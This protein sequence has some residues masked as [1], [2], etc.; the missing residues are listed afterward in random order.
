M[1]YHGATR[2]SP[3]ARSRRRNRLRLANGVAAVALFLAPALGTADDTRNPT[4][5]V[6]LNLCT[7]ELVLRLADRQKIASVTYLATTSRVSNVADLAAHIPAN[8]GL[9]EE[10][11]PL[12]PDLVVAGRYTA[13][14]AVALLKRT[15]IAVLDL[16]VPRNLDEIRAQYR[17]MGQ[18]LGE[19]ERAERIIAEMDSRLASIPLSPAS[20]RPRAMVF[21]ANGYTIGKGSL[22]DEIITRAGMENLSATLGIDNYGQIPLETLVTSPV[23]VLILSSF[24]DG[25]PAMATEVLRHPVLAKMSDRM[26]IT[27]MPGRLWACAGPGNIDAIALLNKAANEAR[28]KET[29]E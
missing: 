8:H 23:D 21:N 27:V 25:P 24:R 22:T 28:G 14:T 18:A 29:R 20:T 11:V 7:D 26:R 15:G 10:I 9:A 12:N 16:D 6:S 4:R 3:G 19:E 13:R 2:C 5:I 1:E 17:R